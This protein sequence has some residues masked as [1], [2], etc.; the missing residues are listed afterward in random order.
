M[1]KYNL[2][3]IINFNPS[4]IEIYVKYFSLYL[5]VNTLSKVKEKISRKRPS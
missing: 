1:N 4:Y 3:K 5:S 2:I